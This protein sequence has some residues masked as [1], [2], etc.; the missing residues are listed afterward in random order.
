MSTD[1][2]SRPFVARNPKTGQELRYQTDQLLG[3][4]GSGQVYLARRLPSDDDRFA[5]EARKVALKVVHSPKWKGYLAEEARLLAKLQ[6]DAERRSRGDRSFVHRLVRIGADGDVLE[7]DEGVGKASLIELEYLDGKTLQNWYDADWRPRGPI[8]AA[9]MLDEV[10][11][12]AHELGESLMQLSNVDG[13]NIVHRDIKPENIMRTSQGL[14]LFDLNV[15][16]EVDE[17]MTR[18]IGTEGYM[19]PEVKSGEPYD[20]R[21]DLYSTGV[22]LWEIVHRRRFDPHIELRKEGGRL[23]L[24][25]PTEDAK[26]LPDDVVAP[27]GELLTGLLVEQDRRMRSPAD[28]LSLVMNL[29]EPLLRNRRQADQLGALDMISL[30]FELRPSGLASV[31]TD[32]TARVP[33]QE[34]QDFLRERM[35]VED[36]LVPW[37]DQFVT[38]AATAPRPKRTLLLL[39]GN[40]GDG[41]SHLLRRLIRDRWKSRPE[42]LARIHYI[43]DATH[44]LRPDASQYERLEGFFAPFADTDSKDDDRVH[45]IAMNTGIAIRFFEREGVRQRF[46]TLYRELQRQLGLRRTAGNETSPPWR[47]EVVNLD[48]R[49]LVAK[50]EGG[51]PSFFEGMLDRLDPE[52][53]GSI[54][55]PKWS[56]CQTRCPASSLCP[57]AFNLRALRKEAPRRAVLKILERAALDTEIHL[58]PRNLWALLYWVFTGGIERYRVEGRN[59]TDMPCD[60]VRAQVQAGNSD[61]LMQGHFSELLFAKEGAGAPS[62]ALSRLDPAFSSVQELD[63]REAAQIRDAQNAASRHITQE[64]HD[65]QRRWW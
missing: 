37:L 6:Q 54:P 33:H 17:E 16:R 52:R 45:L 48:L 40:A 50:G 5:D 8:P 22:I 59:S 11:R 1:T 32:T 13:E 62:V 34:L 18:Y 27:L 31:V 30:L 42:I 26:K 58:S 14:R 4:G 29:R 53:E 21:A 36:P 23:D 61:W 38:E 19:A 9:E 63:R 44:A 64:S 47:V 35:R 15:A 43:S 12:I 25:W 2:G 65:R 24:K 39:A 46:A 60:V 51:S 10:L 20:Q 57:V 56:E 49:N 28:L 41:K 3:T 55:H 7:M